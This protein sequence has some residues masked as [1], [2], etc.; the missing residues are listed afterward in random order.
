MIEIQSSLVH[1]QKR[2]GGNRLII[3]LDYPRA[4]PSENY[5]EQLT[6]LG[7]FSTSQG[8]NFS[9]GWGSWV[10]FLSFKRLSERVIRLE[11]RLMTHG[12]CLQ[13]TNNQDSPRSFEGTH[14]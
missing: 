9:F 10:S 12:R 7:F 5:Q 4:A 3:Q 8:L 1:K 14:W 2:Y 13:S 11:S 6:A